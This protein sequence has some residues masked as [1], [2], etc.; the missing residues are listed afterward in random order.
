MYK[1]AYVEQGK[2]HAWRDFWIHGRGEPD[3][4]LGLTEHVVANNLTDA[5]KQVRRM[6]PE[7]VIMSEGS[8]RISSC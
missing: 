8:G 2:Q 4:A 1:V 5:I 7:Y 3:S 6:H